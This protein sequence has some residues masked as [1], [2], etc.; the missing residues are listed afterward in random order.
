MFLKDLNTQGQSYGQLITTTGGLYEKEHLL[1][2]SA[3]RE[4]IMPYLASCRLHY[5][6]KETVVTEKIEA[7]D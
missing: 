4:T 1:A 6:E 2:A 3:M 5:K 7:E